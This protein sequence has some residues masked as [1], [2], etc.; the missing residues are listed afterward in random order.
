MSDTISKYWEMVEDGTME[1]PS[2]L[3]NL[4]EK[5]QQKAIRNLRINN[6]DEIKKLSN[7]LANET[8]NHNSLYDLAESFEKMLTTFLK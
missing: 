4:Q 8:E 7:E 1:P 2:K 3:R 5:Q 6:P